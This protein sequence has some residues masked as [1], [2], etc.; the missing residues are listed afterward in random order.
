[1][2]FHHVIYTTALCTWILFST[3]TSA[4]TC[5][6]FMLLNSAIFGGFV[7]IS[8]IRWNSIIYPCY[9][10]MYDD[11]GV[12]SHNVVFIPCARPPATLIIMMFSH[13][14]R[15]L[16]IQKFIYVGILDLYTERYVDRTWC[17]Q[18]SSLFIHWAGG[19]ALNFV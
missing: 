10:W 8:I 12:S 19:F 5:F 6:S 2:N 15:K 18:C 16:Y 3:Q 11:D 7:L 13:L 1:M 9:H 4:L 17:R 14:F